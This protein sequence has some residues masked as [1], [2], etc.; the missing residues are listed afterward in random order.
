MCN[1]NNNKMTNMT[2][3][4]EIFEENKMRRINYFLT[5]RL[6]IGDTCLILNSSKLIFKYISKS[7][8][9]VIN[10]TK[11]LYKKFCSFLFGK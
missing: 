3:T 10:T 6:Y 2:L 5:K 8:L 7:T 11:F 9:I 4:K 1:N